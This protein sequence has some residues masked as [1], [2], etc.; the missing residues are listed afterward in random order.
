M[1]RGTLEKPKIKAVPSQ[2]LSEKTQTE[3]LVSPKELLNE[4]IENLVLEDQ[5]VYLTQLNFNATRSIRAAEDHKGAWHIEIPHWEYAVEYVDADSETNQ[6]WV[7]DTIWPN[8]VYDNV[9]RTLGLSDFETA[10]SFIPYYND[11][12]TMILADELYSVGQIKTRNIIHV[13]DDENKVDFYLPYWHDYRIDRVS[14][15]KKAVND[16][17]LLGPMSLTYEKDIKPAPHNFEKDW[18]DLVTNPCQNVDVENWFGPLLKCP[19]YFASWFQPTSSAPALFTQR[20]DIAMDTLSDLT[21]YLSLS[22]GLLFV[23]FFFYRLHGL[24]FWWLNSLDEEDFLN[25]RVVSG[26]NY[27]SEI[28]NLKNLIVSVEIFFFYISIFFFILALFY[29]PFTLPIKLKQ[30]PFDFDAIRLTKTMKTVSEDY[31]FDIEEFNNSFDERV[32]Y[33]DQMQYYYKAKSNIVPWDVMAFTQF[34]ESYPDDPNFFVFRQGF[35]DMFG[36]R[37]RYETAYDTLFNEFNLDPITNRQLL[38]NTLLTME[39]RAI[40]MSTYMLMINTK[41]KWYEGWFG[42]PI[43]LAAHTYEWAQLY[44]TDASSFERVPSKRRKGRFTFAKKNVRAN[45]NRN[46]IVQQSRTYPPERYNTLETQYYQE[47]TEVEEY[48]DGFFEGF[49]RPGT[50]LNENSEKPSPFRVLK[51]LIIVWLKQFLL[52]IGFYRKPKEKRINFY[53]EKNLDVSKQ[54]ALYTSLLFEEFIKV[55]KGKLTPSQQYEKYLKIYENSKN[56]W[57]D[58]WDNIVRGDYRYETD[59]HFIL[60]V[61]RYI[62]AQIRKNEK[63][64][65]IRDERKKHRGFG[66]EYDMENET[67]PALDIANINPPFTKLNKLAYDVFLNN[68]GDLPTADYFAYPPRIHLR[69]V[70]EYPFSPQNERLFRTRYAPSIKKPKYTKSPYAAA[71]REVMVDRMDPN[72][73]KRREWE[74]FSFWFETQLSQDTVWSVP[75]YATPS[76]VTTTTPRIWKEWTPWSFITDVYFV[77]NFPRPFEL[78]LHYR[79][80]EEEYWFKPLNFSF[81]YSPSINPNRRF[82]YIRNPLDV[83]GIENKRNLAVHQNIEARHYANDP[84]K[85]LLFLEFL[86]ENYNIPPQPSIVKTAV[87]QRSFFIPQLLSRLGWYDIRFFVVPKQL[88]EQHYR[89]VIAIAFFSILFALLTGRDTEPMDRRQYEAIKAQH[90]IKAWEDRTKNNETQSR[91]WV[92]Y[93][94][95]EAKQLE[96]EALK[97]AEDEKLRNSPS[98]QALNRKKNLFYIKQINHLVRRPDKKLILEKRTYKK[99][100]KEVPEK[101]IRYLALLNST[102]GMLERKFLNELIQRYTSRGK[103]V[104]QRLLDM[105]NKIYNKFRDKVAQNNNDKN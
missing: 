78:A 59:P 38:F 57:Y 18:A 87:P 92:K 10:N 41:P 96:K 65:F 15:G 28:E 70:I 17:D 83:F 97:A 47:I 16:A 45:S 90:F 91:L 56:K 44:R 42:T 99:G 9:H 30:K 20:D 32:R 29:V 89:H 2:S 37:K 11:F 55:E 36:M 40:N 93:D 67:Y 85:F 86:K 104:P 88:Y 100:Y 79:K 50:L 48:D 27:R 66:V 12:E 94:K 74:E 6:E 21:F 95:I 5:K 49:L 39:T 25:L 19:D 75:Y 68:Y 102:I 73:Y 54:N 58:F 14:L 7:D 8:S 63:V 101:K 34:I 24:I 98:Y 53:K 1:E 69:K 35:E 72:D 103:Q 81:E 52:D 80:P 64:V 43:H 105:Q 22:C 3:G 33:E 31:E 62:E 13:E 76:T 77:S 60:M 84:K 26:K 82:K 23:F 4:R 61:K 51:D 71:F 46:L